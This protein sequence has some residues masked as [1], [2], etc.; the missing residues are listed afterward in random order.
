MSTVHALPQPRFRFSETVYIV[1]GKRFLSYLRAYAH[2][3]ALIARTGVK[4][5]IL[6]NF[7]T[8]SV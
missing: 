7:T 8:R 3:E 6:T 1:H 2:R 5:A 4:H